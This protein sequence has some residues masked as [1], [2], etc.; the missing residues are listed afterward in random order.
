MTESIPSG[1]VDAHCH[2]TDDRLWNNLDSILRECE[3]VGI[4]RWVLAGYSPQDWARQ[5]VLR[6]KYNTRIVASFGLHPWWVC[7]QTEQSIDK[8]LA[9]LESQLTE[10]SLL[11]ETGLDAFG[12][13]KDFLALQ[14]RAFL[15]Q[16]S[17]AQKANKPLV[18]HVVRTHEK[19][20]SMLDAHAPVR[21][22]VHSYS[23]TV[24]EVR[25]YLDLGLCIS[26]GGSVLGMQP[27]KLKQLV[28]SIPQDRLLI[29]T[30]APDQR[31]RLPELAQETL[32]H[33]RNL[34]RIAHAIADFSGKDP[35]RLLD[36]S[37][38]NIERVLA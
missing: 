35:I 22:W 29:E 37:R 12:P 6:E 20:I 26:L 33:P 38:I 10:I 16:L 13:R 17:L 15:A 5:K 4:Q 2:L 36:N 8:A 7:T 18:L 23:G 25:R 31:P 34:I 1:W 19:A 11:G 32:N 27:G 30:D 9:D 24:S 28:E 3:Q 21:G 14:E